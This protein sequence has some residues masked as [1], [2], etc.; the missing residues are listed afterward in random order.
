MSNIAVLASGTGSNFQALLDADLSPSK[1]VVLIANNPKAPVME[2]ARRA[3]IPAVLI[4]HRAHKTRTE[5]EDALIAELSVHSVDWVVLAGFMRILT[6]HFV[7]AFADRIVNIHPALCPAFPG[8]DAQRQALEAGVKITGCTVH[9]VDTGVDTGPILAQVAVPILEK[10]DEA[11]LKARILAQEHALLPAVVRAL[12]RG[13]LRTDERGHCWFAPASP[14]E[15]SD[16]GADPV[17][18]S[19]TTL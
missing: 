3:G 19:P 2:R 1:I 17:L 18:R 15:T 9:L 4:D 16:P 14:A 11:T 5:F 10:D 12:G 6:P 13:L 8:V 7:H